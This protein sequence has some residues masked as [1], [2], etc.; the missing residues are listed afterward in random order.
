MMVALVAATSTSFVSCKDTNEDE[1][2]QLKNLM[3]DQQKE[4]SQDI[5]DLQNKYATIASVEAVDK[6]F[7]D[8]DTKVKSLDNALKG[9]SANL[10]KAKEDIENLKKEVADVRADLE[11]S[12]KNLVYGVELSGVYSNM[13][14][15]INIPGFEPKML[16][17]NYGVAGEAG[18]FPKSS[19]FKGEKLE[20]QANETLGAGEKEYGNY[21]FAGYIYANINRYYEDLPIK[22]KQDGGIFNFSLA[23]TDGTDVPGLVITNTDKDGKATS[24]VLRWGWTRDAENNIYKFRAEF[25][26]NNASK[27]APAKIDLSKFKADVKR[28]W[29]ERNSSTN[30][31]AFGT[32]LADLYYNLATKDYNMDKYLLKVTW[33]EDSN[34]M[35]HIATSEAE[36]VFATIKPLTFNSGGA[37]SEKVHSTVGSANHMIEKLEPYINKIFKRVQKDLK[38]DKYNMNMDLFDEIKH[39][40]VDG[41][42]VYYV[43]ID[44]DK[45]N[46]SIS[47]G[48]TLGNNIEVD[49]TDIVNPMKDA[50]QNMNDLLKNMKDLLNK[51]YGK[52]VTNWIEKFT[53]KFDQVIA[54]H[55]DQILQP[56][57]LAIDENSNVGRVSGIESLPYVATGEITLKPTTY[58]GEF[59]A[60]CY[61]K[62]V[63]CKD[64]DKDGF[65]EILRDGDLNKELKFTPDSGKL[66][67]IVYEAVDF[68][69]NTRQHTYYILGK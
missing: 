5:T 55:Q 67:E 33:A 7:T 2:Y 48:V 40:T 12:F 64:I 21:G 6:K 29:Q 14:G 46:E 10:E 26:G 51:N 43:E 38:I 19:L 65:N 9:D 39:K 66:Y 4:L 53:N 58:T 61:A 17:N 69:G 37:I 42:T 63:G 35:A 3:N 18:S 36:L 50:C 24:D 1:L 28:V 31:K 59:I 22:A 20:W 25:V 44:K 15:S 41:K 60:P 30:K 56:V 68:F 11:N 8:L 23:T 13:T 45:F 62:F 54:N 32:L 57:L 16:I 27:Y 47:G 34:K 52:S 49:V